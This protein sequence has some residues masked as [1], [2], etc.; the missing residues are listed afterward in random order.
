MSWA[1]EGREMADKGGGGCTILL[2]MTLK[3]APPEHD[4]KARSDVLSFA[5][6]VISA[7]AQAVARMEH[8]LQTGFEEAVARILSGPGALV[9]T[10]VGKAGHVARKVSATFASTGT[11]SHFLS[12]ADALHGDLGA[13]RAGDLLL[14]FSASGESEEIVRLLDVIRR[15]GHPLIA[16]TATGRS[17]LGRFAD[18]VLEMGRVEEACPLRLAP[19]CSTTAM[20]ALGDALALTVMRERHFTADDFALFHPAGQLGR[21]L[22]R[23]HEAMTFRAGENMPTAREDQTVGEVLQ[24]ASRITRRPGAVVVVDPTGRLC[25]IF[26][27][28][29][30]R[31]LLLSAQD[32]ALSLPMGQVMTRAPKRVKGEALAS[33]AMAIMRRHRIDEL[34]VVDDEDRPVGMIDVQDLVVLK[35]FDVAEDAA[36]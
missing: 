33:E 3:Q 35:L 16:I 26:S 18:V 6:E 34:P 19:S 27:D 30:L 20:L 28:G 21:K 25:G 10:G 32:R 1:Q 12:P 22:L 36:T 7:E 23:V 15:L 8:A 29:D 9:T 13:V 17:T 24:E 4:R 11:P 2:P 31:R 14:V 5:R